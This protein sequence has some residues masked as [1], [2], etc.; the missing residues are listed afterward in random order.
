MRVSDE[1]QRLFPEIQDSV[2]GLAHELY[3]A[4][5]TVAMCV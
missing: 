1:C 2:L 3:V 5:P 4:L